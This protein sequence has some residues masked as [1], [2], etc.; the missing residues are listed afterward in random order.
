MYVLLCRGGKGRGDFVVAEDSAPQHRGTSV[1]C[2]MRMFCC[3]G[4]GKDVE[5][6]SWLK[7]QPHNNV[8]PEPCGA[9]LLSMEATARLEAIL[10]SFTP[11]TTTAVLKVKPAHI[12]R[13]RTFL[14]FDHLPNNT[15]GTTV[16]AQNFTC[17]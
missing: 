3:V 17:G 16:V 9:E 10:D 2:I 4:E 15:S 14:L 8:A 11:Q 13:V 5:I 1:M 6:L 12:Y 7:A